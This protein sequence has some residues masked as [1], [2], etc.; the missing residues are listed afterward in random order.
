MEIILRLS[1]T[2]TTITALS[3]EQITLFSILVTL[4]I[5]LWGKHSEL[6][7]KK[8]ELRRIEYKKFINLLQKMYTKKFKPD[9]RTKQE[10]FDS[11]VSLLIYGSKKMYRNYVF[12]RDYST[13]PIIINSRYNRNN[14]AIYVVADILKTVRHE[15]GM[16]RFSELESNEVL[17]FFVNDIGMNPLSKIESYKAKRNISM[18]K[19]ELFMVD[20]VNFSFLKKIYFEFISPVFNG[21]KIVFKYLIHIPIG[22]F[23]IFIFPSL[24]KID[25]QDEVK[26]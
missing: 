16:S 5:F 26:Q 3:I 4:L 12:F 2:L 20:R 7:Q 21:V 11:G 1:K 24:K 15:V 22:R 25:K 23:V 9:D 13:N 19:F 10:F 18:L 8:Q 6:K 17:S 14:A